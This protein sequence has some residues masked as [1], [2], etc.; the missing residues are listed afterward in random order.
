MPRDS[1]YGRRKEGFLYSL[2]NSDVTEEL[3]QRIIKRKQ[4]LFRESA[5]REGDPA[6]IHEM[7]YSL[8]RYLDEAQV[9]ELAQCYWITNESP[10]NL[11]VAGASG[12]GKS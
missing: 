3:E 12:T 4:R 2:P 9:K 5:I 8:E 11:L 7:I 10:P 6:N 1:Q